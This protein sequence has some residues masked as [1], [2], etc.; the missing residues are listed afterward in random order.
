MTLT[1]R[2]D[3]FSFPA[4]WKVSWTIPSSASS[5]LTKT[6][7]LTAVASPFQ[8]FQVNRKPEFWFR[9][10]LEL[11]FYLYPEECCL[12]F[13]QPGFPDFPEWKRLSFSPCPCTGEDK[14]DS[15]DTQSDTEQSLL[16]HLFFIKAL[17]SE[18]PCY[19]LAT[20]I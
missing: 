14:A 17:L 5:S 18:F 12:K 15:I 2:S 4:I 20:L 1:G 7:A 16:L 6:P 10:R 11:V 13:Q 19:N 8:C 3:W 9:F